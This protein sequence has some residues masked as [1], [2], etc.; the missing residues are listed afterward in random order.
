[1]VMAN[2]L[3][4]GAVGIDRRR[5]CNLT[6]LLRRLVV[7]S[8]SWRRVGIAREGLA[9]AKQRE[10]NNRHEAS[11]YKRWSELSI[12]VHGMFPLDRDAEHRRLAFPRG[13][14]E[15]GRSLPQ[16]LP[17]K[18]PRG[19]AHTHRG[20]KRLFKAALAINDWRRIEDED[21]RLLIQE[22]ALIFVGQRHT[23]A[24]S[25][26][27]HWAAE[28]VGGLHRVLVRRDF[29]V[30]LLAGLVADRRG[31]CYVFQVNHAQHVTAIEGVAQLLG[32]QFD[33]NWKAGGLAGRWIE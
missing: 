24:H 7:H 8:T 3:D 20:F 11:D 27:C 18:I 32:G 22:A 29:K 10:R 6:N 9:G 21:G 16:L 23:G 17:F 26:D 30:T 14:W 13:A 4:G 1:M 15:R 33:G 31:G 25:E 19:P 2:G 5:S 12:A 28:A